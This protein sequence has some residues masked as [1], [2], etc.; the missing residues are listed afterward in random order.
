MIKKIKKI[1][2]FGIFDNYQESN[3]LPDFKEYNLIYGWNAT[4]KTTLS[5]L[6]RCFELQAIHSDFPEAVFQLKTIDDEI[7][8]NEN[9][10]QY[11]N[12]RV[13][14]KDFIDENVFTQQ[15]TINP[16]YVLG[17][18]NIEQKKKLEDLKNK[19]EE[20]RTQLN[21]KKKDLQIK[22]NEKEKLSKEKAKQIKDFVRTEGTDQYTDYDKSDFCNNIE[23]LNKEEIDQNFLKEEELDEKKKAINQNIKDKI[24]SIKEQT[25]FDEKNIEQINSI[26]RKE[27]ISENIE[28]LK[29]NQSLNK[30]VK[31]GLDLYNQSNEGNCHFCEQPMPKERIESL[32]KHFNQD[33]I[34]LI[35][36][37]D[38]L[39]Q[40]WKLKK[41]SISITDKNALYENLSHPFQEKN[42]KLN[43]EIERY[44][45]FIE[46][47]LNQIKLKKE[48]P[49]QNVEEI[50]YEAF[51]LKDLIEKING[52]IS[53]HNER[54][55]NF[56]ETR[57]K[58]KK[59]I[60]KHF[61]SESY[62]EYQALKSE[63]SDLEISVK[64][65]R[66]ENSKIER[67][68][69]QLSQKKRDYKITTK[70]INKK[71]KSFLGREELV[72]QPTETEDEGYYIKRVSNGKFAK[73]LSEG[74]KA[75]V[76]LT[77][78]LSKLNEE[79]FDINNGIVV[80]DDPISSLDSNSIFQAFGFIKSEVKQAKQI[81][82]LT[83]NFDF[84]KHIKHWFKRDCKEKSEFFMIKNFSTKDKRTAKLS[85]LD[86]LLKDYDSE[87]QYLFSLLYNLKTNDG[88]NFK[89]VY[90][91]PN[92]ARKF[93]E[94]FLSFNF[95]AERNQEELY[96]KAREKTEF[97]PERIEKIKRF[98]NSHS[99]SDIDKMTGWDISQWSEGKQII[100]DILELVEKLYKEHYE[101]LCRISKQK[102]A[103]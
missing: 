31:E 73:S 23:F 33:Y 49:F 7:I 57:K 83:H 48:N 47:I 60:E 21:S 17:K 43:K 2:N 71:L 96:S 45:Q 99:H 75:A 70:N 67:E 20:K 29:N 89:E 25:L 61:L 50:H 63:I 59:D 14:N 18:E 12:I 80:I 76:A 41:I 39:N 32:K 1:N 68:I 81:F 16:I 10:S 84:F 15:N 36:N 64:K 30:W 82:I 55:D 34:N 40:E 26:L 65:M 24:E 91:L 95:P 42:N 4:G 85:S 66:D 35:N 102:I 28:K 56:V 11:T 27:I 78:F 53:N 37:I 58:E 22:K 54:T 72:F 62:K 52:I 6:L 79:N 77:Y 19:Q 86:N 94:T 74:E 87:Y 8:K 98:I 90:P 88:N 93:M 97:D 13:F 103:T 101:G 92:V 100:K 44:N 3:D 38:N 46:T 5:R 51:Q 69:E 9:L